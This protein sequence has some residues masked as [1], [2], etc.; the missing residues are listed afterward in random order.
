MSRYETLGIPNQEWQILDEHVESL[1]RAISARKRMAPLNKRAIRE[2]E[3][4][5]APVN[6][7]SMGLAAILEQAGRRFSQFAR[8]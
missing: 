3:R 6:L 2:L 4:V 7:M 5:G 8:A 1:G